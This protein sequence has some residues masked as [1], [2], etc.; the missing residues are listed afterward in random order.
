MRIYKSYTY[1]I[2]WTALDKWYY[3]VRWGNIKQNKLP[4]ED[5]WV[6]YFTSSKYVKEFRKIHGE[7]DFIK[8]D[9]TFDNISD[10]LNYEKHKL[11]LED[12]LN[13]NRWINKGLGGYINPSIMKERFKTGT[14]HFQKP[15][16]RSKLQQER[17]KNGTHN[18]LGK[19]NPIHKRIKDGTI[20]TLTKEWSEFQSNIQKE[21]IK[22]GTHHF[23]DIGF[24]KNIQQSR[25]QNG[26]HQ[27]Q[28]YYVCPHCNKKG[29][30]PAMIRWH[31]DNCKNK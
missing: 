2:G 23:L 22:N 3:G 16:F 6:N 19:R 18:L 9:K 17:V 21:R 31:F 13:N 1:L 30:S 14:H 4:N 8:I 28:K 10:A 12:V 29:K 26:T 7:P 5:L 27:N 11:L 24:S 20:H 25:L 15:G